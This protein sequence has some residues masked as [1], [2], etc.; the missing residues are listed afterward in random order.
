VPLSES[1]KL[2]ENREFFLHIETNWQFSGILVV[3]KLQE[4]IDFPAYQVE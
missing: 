3:E 4:S 1:P 2:I